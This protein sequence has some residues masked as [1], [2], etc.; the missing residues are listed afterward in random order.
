MHDFMRVLWF[1]FYENHASI[2]PM[3]REMCQ[4]QM[5]DESWVIFAF[6]LRLYIRYVVMIPNWNGIPEL[7]FDIRAF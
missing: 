3:F 5:A 7:S 2:N 6:T 4:I 1:Q